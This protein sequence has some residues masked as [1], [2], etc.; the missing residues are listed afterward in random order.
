[1]DL[2]KIEGLTEEQSAA[3]TAQYNADTEGLRN[4]NE[5][6]L[7]EKK[8][9]QATAAEQAQIAEDARKA[10][11]K[12]EEEKLKA[13]NDMEGLKAHYE[14]QLA[15]AT[16]EA[17]EKAKLAESALLSR[18]KTAVLNK[19]LGLVHDDYKA[20][21]EAMLSNML[22]ISYNDQGEAITEFKH[23]G[24]VVAKN[25]EEFKGWASE[26][27]AFKKILNGVDSSGAN[28]TQSSSSAA[29]AN[30]PYNEMSLKEQAAYLQNV[31]P[32][33]N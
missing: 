28:T 25:V 8:T 31:N 23:N 15:S 6:L 11:I 9:V 32:Q 2:S 21:S 10:A 5:Q 4:K 13:A 17:N 20:V 7:G 1:M 27:D 14:E 22:N 24:E 12:A 19:A 29:P 30:K 16:A 3:I 26:Q 18:D 33:R